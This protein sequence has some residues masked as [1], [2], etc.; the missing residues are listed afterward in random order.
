MTYPVDLTNCDREPIHLL[1][2][3]Q[4]FGFLL[5]VSSDWIIQRCSENIE[6]FLGRKVNDVLG[7]PLAELVSLD[8]VETVRQRLRHLHAQDAVERVIRVPL[9]NSGELYDLALHLSGQAI[10]IEAEPS[11]TTSDFVADTVRNMTARLHVAPDIIMLC[12]QAARQMR[13][14]T[15]FDRVM[16]YRFAEDGAGQVIAEARRQDVPSY[17]GLRFP[18]S[19]IPAQARALYERNWLR[20]IADVADEGSAVLPQRDPQGAPLDLSMSV[21]R[22]VSP[23][24]IEYLK[25][26]GVG[27]SLSVSILRQGRLWGLFACHHMQPCVLSL[28]TRTAAELFGQMFSWILESQEHRSEIEAEHRAREIHDQL[29]TSFAQETSVEAISLETHRFRLALPCDGVAIWIDGKATLDGKTPSEE[30]LAGL[31]RFLNTAAASRVFAT[32]E[33][34]KTYAPGKDFVERAAGLLA[35]PISRAPRD[36]ILFFREEQLRKVSW[37]GD[38]NKPVTLGTNG[39]RLTPRK[40]F[41]LWQE[42]VQGRSEPWSAQDRDIAEHL[43]ITLIEIILHM[44]GVVAA[45]R[46]QAEARQDVLI[47][48]LNH[49]VRNILALIRGIVSQSGNQASSTAELTSIIGGR[50]QALARA[51][52]QINRSQWSS[53][54]LRDLIIAELEAYIGDGFSRAS[55]EGPDV[56]VAPQA[57]SALALVIHEMATN[58]AKYGSLSVPHGHLAIDWRLRDGALLLFWRETNGPPVSQPTRQGFGTTV[59]S[60]SIP[61]ELKGEAR[62]SYEATGVSGEFFIPS[63]FIRIGQPNL[64]QQA[65]TPPAQSEAISLRFG[66]TILLV[67]DNLLIAL[68]G[69]AMLRE[70]GFETV[71]LA[72]TLTEALAL[73]DENDLTAAVLDFDLGGQTTSSLAAQLRE[74]DIPFVYATGYGATLQLDSETADAK[75]VQKPYSTE[76]LRAALAEAGL[77]PASTAH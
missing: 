36:Y 21:L 61:F 68:D 25:N 70:L 77:K 39:E 9:T 75:I 55:L 41:A 50:L 73:A 29:M 38:P 23:I 20:I 52:D 43:R 6:R 12:E 32:D 59:I 47:A 8:A 7:L 67:E 17:F 51:H 69:E 37:A 35:I 44:S 71:M 60:R 3:V 11:Q 56:L 48:E 74:R 15:G 27:A 31:V 28:S 64:V 10:I 34:G 4:S 40:S 1:G 58:A 13:D 57:F 5:A 65:E 72:A 42:I 63:K 53:S 66:G 33:I 54:S 19:D 18:A 16:V 45:E 76:L 46:R 2:A 22:S 30:E 26:M 62:V 24:H 49:R 14:L